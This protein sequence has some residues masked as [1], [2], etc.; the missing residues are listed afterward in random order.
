MALEVEDGTGK[1]NAESFCSVAAFR[2]YHARRGVDV[3]SLT[4]DQV[5]A[6][7]VKATDYMQSKYADRWRGVR[8]KYEQALEWPRAYAL[9]SEGYVI[10]PSDSYYW[11]TVDSVPTPV[12]NAC[13]ELAYKA[14]SDDLMPDVGRRTT[15]ETVGPI[16]VVYA[17]SSAER[18]TNEYPAVD[19]MLRRLLCYDDG[20]T[21]SMVR[22]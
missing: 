1:S 13:A 15:Q 14:N 16:T 11:W 8:R 2:A 9:R 18:E 12:V 7:L 22:G 5:E 6:L 21:G 19:A 17:D 3:T 20:I 10:E 4:D